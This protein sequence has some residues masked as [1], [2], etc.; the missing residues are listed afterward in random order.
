MRVEWG[1]KKRRGPLREE[2]EEK[3]KKGGL[4]EW[5]TLRRE[6]WKKPKKGD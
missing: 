2:R 4:G 5:R 6:R 3:P 1:P